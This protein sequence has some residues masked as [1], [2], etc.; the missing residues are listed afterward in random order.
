MAGILVDTN[1][2]I[3]AADPAGSWYD[4]SARQLE[5]A[6]DTEG[7]C[8]NPIIYAELAGYIDSPHLMDELLADLLLEK[9]DLPWNAAFAAGRAF[10]RYRR[11]GGQKTAPLPD[12]YIGAHAQA[13]GL[14]LLTRDATR[15]RSYFPG[16]RLIAPDC[17]P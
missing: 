2:I 17:A 8:I 4:W 5:K 3:D 10:V 9:A 15:Y 13:S 11:S 1:V 12:F 6:A 14:A 16:I 7:V